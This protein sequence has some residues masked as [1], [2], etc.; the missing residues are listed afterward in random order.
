MLDENGFK[1]KT[2]AVLVEEIEMKAKE[3]FGDINLSPRS[4][5]GILIR[6]FAWFLAIVWQLAEKVYNNSFPSTAE[7]ISLDRA[8]AFKGLTRNA[9]EYAYGQIEITGEPGAIVDA[10]FVVGTK[11][12]VYFETIEDVT[13]DVVTGKALA[14]IYAQ[15]FG[16]QGNVTVGE[17]TEI[18]NPTEDVFSVVNP[19]DTEGGQ[20]RETDTELQKRYAASPINIESSSIDSI[21]SKLLTTPGVRDAVVRENTLIIEKDGLPPKCIAPFVF[22]GDDVAV[23]NAIFTQKAA[24]I[25]SF[26][27]TVIEVTDKKSNKHLIGF[28]RP[29]IVQLFIRAT[30]VRK[31]SF[32]SDGDSVIRT[33]IIQY[34]GGTDE[35]GIVYPGLGVGD[36]VI[37]N[38]IIWS[39]IETGI[40]DDVGVELSTDGVSFV[41][42]NIEVL[43]ISVAKTTFDKVVVL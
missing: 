18:L 5:L 33:K 15:E 10:G 21:E 39:I 1:R 43:S 4:F 36:D 34:V 37:I 41:K 24:G 31:T 40:V 16:S 2:Y 12:N 32:P 13:L 28:T 27:T 6:L 38:Q 29:N 22:G 11:R 17:I 23:A 30:L 3:V 42:T 7:G 35:S 26:G 20:D 9:A 19:I 25:Q 8:V 14:T